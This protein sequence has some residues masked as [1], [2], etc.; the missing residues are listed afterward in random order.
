MT[1]SQD[2]MTTLIQQAVTVA[3]V[4]PPGLIQTLAHTIAGYPHQQWDTVRLRV[5]QTVPQHQQRALVL[6]FVDAWQQ[7][8]PALLPHE[9]ALM[10]RTASITARTIRQQQTVEL[11]WTG[12]IVPQVALRRTD[13]ALLQVIH[14][15]HTS[16]LIVSFA[17]YHI[18][19][20][21]D[22]IVQASARGVTIRICVEA[23]EPSGQ[24]MA[25]DTI[26]ALGAAVTQH[27]TIYIWPNEQRS[28]DAHGR[29]G[30]LHVKCAVG[31]TQQLFLSSANL[32][33]HALNRN[34]ELGVLISGGN[35]PVTVVHQ[36]D[37][38]IETGVLKVVG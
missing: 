11:V 23:P 32:T 26:H 13:Q 29:A 35:G 19:A 14:Q 33:D 16:L 20:I 1:V 30:V 4:L 18:P 24:K 22:S 31:D 8:A 3:E 2:P 10:L 9:M 25:Y 7:R 38:L 36:F 5:A 34:M 15:A 27:A 37:R 28:R 17:V 21:A 12:P 6:A